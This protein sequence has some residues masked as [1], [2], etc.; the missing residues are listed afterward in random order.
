[1]T[2]E[3]ANIDLAIIERD[4]AQALGYTFTEGE[5]KVDALTMRDQI[6]VVLA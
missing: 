4:M 2:T 1:M 6:S 3:F 5:D